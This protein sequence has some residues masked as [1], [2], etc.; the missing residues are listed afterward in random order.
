MNEPAGIPK[1]LIVRALPLTF[2]HY[3]RGGGR[4][5]GETDNENTWLTM[6]IF[7][8]FTLHEDI[9]RKDCMSGEEEQK[10]LN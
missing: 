9:L 7:S 1:K 6:P 2:Y 5:E 3:W 8:C 10:Y 4:R